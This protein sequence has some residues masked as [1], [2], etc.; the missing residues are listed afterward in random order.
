[1][2]IIETWNRDD[3]IR[4]LRWECEFFMDYMWDV[5]EQLVQGR[6]SLRAFDMIYQDTY[7]EAKIASQKIDAAYQ[8]RDMW[9]LAMSEWGPDYISGFAESRQRCLDILKEKWIPLSVC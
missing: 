5:V 8:R 4:E 1:M 3:L 7:V 6:V 9:R 2:K